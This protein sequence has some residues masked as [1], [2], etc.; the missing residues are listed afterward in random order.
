MQTDTFQALQVLQEL[1]GSFL[2]PLTGTQLSDTL[3]HVIAPVLN[4]LTI[5]VES[6]ID[7]LTE[8]WMVKNLRD[9]QLHLS[10]ETLK[11][12]APN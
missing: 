2:F 9:V 11:H 4:G 6:G 5:P 3:L 1:V 8:H 7:R 10:V 12:L